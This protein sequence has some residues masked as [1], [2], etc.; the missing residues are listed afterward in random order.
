M[1]KQT[2]HIGFNMITLILSIG[3]LLTL[4]ACASIVETDDNI[5]TGVA[6]SYELPELGYSYDALEPYIDAATME[7]HHAMHFN[8][9]TTKLNEALLKH[10]SFQI[11]L[12][13]ALANLSLVPTDIRTAV[14]NHGGG[15]YN[16]KLYFSILKI[17]HG[18][19]PTGALEFEI[20]KD[21]GSYD[22]FETAF[23]E[24]SASHFGSG[25]VWLIVTN[26]GLE[27]VSTSNQDTPLNLGVPIL[28][29]DI[30]EHAYYLN[31]Q[32]RRTEYITSFFSI[33]N[34]DIVMA[35]YDEAR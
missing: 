13:S 21:F 3:L 26:Q 5:P 28:N 23:S 10:P 25:W 9:Y 33:V 14:Q 6:M 32:N 24:A 7:I 27:I 18:Q 2:K 20:V 16:H 29:I 12:E 4:F 11:P 22:A 15:Y 35:L 34:W 30:W 1:K 31:Y 8:G 17:N 19:R